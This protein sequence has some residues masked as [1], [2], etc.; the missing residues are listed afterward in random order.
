[1]V[2]C[3]FTISNI[4][5]YDMKTYISFLIAVLSFFSAFSDQITATVVFENFTEKTTVS[6]IFYITETN[7]T[8]AIN[9]LDNFTIELPEKGKYE[10]RFYSEDVLAL[11]YFPARITE[12]KNVIT[13]RLENKTEATSS[14]IFQKNNLPIKEIPELTTEQIEEGIATGTINF[15]VHGLV[16]VDQEAADAFKEV[17]GVGFTSE[18]CAIDPIS[19]KRAISTN[20]KIEAYLT[21]KFGED[22]KN[23]TPARPFGLH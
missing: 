16:A 18:N 4:Q 3:I 12:R 11:T 21:S 6:G 23:E 14:D 2:L 20:K 1:M 10:F 22:W 5:S 9:S 19:Y 13:V 8:F 17:Y 15:I 7:Q